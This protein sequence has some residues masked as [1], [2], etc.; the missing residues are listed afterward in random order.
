MKIPEDGHYRISFSGVIVVEEEGSAK[1]MIQDE[2]LNSLAVAETGKINLFL[3]S[4][5][6]LI[7]KGKAVLHISSFCFLNRISPPSK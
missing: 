3:V 1:L 6:K 2:L 5:L 7:I 4:R